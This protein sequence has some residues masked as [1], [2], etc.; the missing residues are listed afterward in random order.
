MPDHYTIRDA[1]PEEFEAIGKL[2]ISVYAQL[3]GFPTPA[4]QPSYYEMLANV[5]AFTTSREA[6]CWLPYHR[7]IPLTAQWC[8]SMR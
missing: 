4:E 2:M 8:I 1:R 3:E 7:Q 6:H 5:G